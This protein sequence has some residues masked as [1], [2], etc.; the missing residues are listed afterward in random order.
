MELCCSCF[1][2]R[3]EEEVRS[4]SECGLKICGIG[5][6]LGTCLCSLRDEEGADERF[7]VAF[8]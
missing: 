3:L 4:C 6:C 7:E 2:I 1:E 8:A 5:A